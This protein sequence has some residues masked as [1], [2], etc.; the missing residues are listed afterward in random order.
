[1]IDQLR[2][3]DHQLFHFFN[4]QLANPVFDLVMP[5]VTNDWVLRAI[6]LMIVG[7]LVIF[8]KRRERIAAIFCIV[9]VALSD[10]ASSHLLKPLIERI[11]PCHVMPEVH[12]LVGCSQGLSF[13]STHA[14]N[15]FGLAALLTP[16]Y[17]RFSLYLIVFATLVSYS[18]IAVG[19]HY[20][21]DVLGGAVVGI[22]CGA[23][24]FLSY[25]FVVKR[26]SGTL[27]R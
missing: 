4:V 25:R 3:L 8:G 2:N 26:I 14:A 16:I 1:M 22:I 27:T 11:R 10:Q 12:L 6:L 13:P 24:T 23:A 17:P 21:F 5:I 19:V 20:P 9:T 15:T 7:G 18:R